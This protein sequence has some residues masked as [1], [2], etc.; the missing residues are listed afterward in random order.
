MK[1]TIEIKKLGLVLELDS[2]D[3]SSYGAWAS[4]TIKSST[5][6]VPIILRGLILQHA[7]LGMDV[8]SDRYVDGVLKVL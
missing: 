3:F 7:I 1:K 4:G 6:L 8:T 2:G 5:K